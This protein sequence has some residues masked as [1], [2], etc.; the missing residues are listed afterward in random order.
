MAAGFQ[1]DHRVLCRSSWKEIATQW[2]LKARHRN[3]ALVYGLARR[4]KDLVDPPPRLGDVALLS[5]NVLRPM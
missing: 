5:Y 1:H 2:L 4:E 3:V